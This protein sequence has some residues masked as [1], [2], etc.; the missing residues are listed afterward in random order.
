MECPGGA[1][2]PG[3]PFFRAGFQV[4]TGV[5]AAHRRLGPRHHRRSTYRLRLLVRKEAGPREAVAQVPG[6]PNPIWLKLGIS[7][8]GGFIFWE[9]ELRLGG[10]RATEQALWGSP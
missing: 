7:M 5:G 3:Q 4:A 2:V 10:P 1:W 6:I 8:S 9:K